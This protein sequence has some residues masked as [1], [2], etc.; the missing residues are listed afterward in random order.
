MKVLILLALIVSAFTL[1]LHDTTFAKFMKFVNS[2]KKIYANHMEFLEKY[3]IFKENLH[4]VMAMQKT[5]ALSKEASTFSWGITPFFDLTTEE[6]AKRY[7]NLKINSLENLRKESLPLTVDSKIKDAPPTYD[8]RKQGAV[9][10]IKNQGMCGSCWAFSAV[11]NLEGQHQIKTGTKVVDL[12]TQQLVDCDKVDQGCNGGLMDDAFNYVKKA[13]G[14]E[15]DSDY[16]YTGSDDKCHF[17]ST[18]VVVK[19]TGYKMATTQNEDDIKNMLYQTGPLSVAMN[20]TPLQ[21]YFF[22]VF[23]PYFSWLCS[24]SGL[25][26]GVLLVGYGTEKGWLYG[27]IKYWIVKN[28]WGKFWGEEGFFRII[29]GTGACGI[30]TY[31]VTA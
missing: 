9:S 22:G 12:S 10:S 8:W 19:D 16:P 28:S 29:R 13:G 6:F 30:N 3:E 4:K 7:L 31:V 5:Q 24:P 23:N 2:N 14:I 20:A 27:E 11:G 17:D 25:N 18:K 15:A 1:E 26:H 21:F